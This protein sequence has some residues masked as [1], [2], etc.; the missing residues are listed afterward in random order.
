[1]KQPANEPSLLKGAF[2]GFAIATLIG[3]AITV[4]MSISAGEAT[5]GG[6]FSILAPIS[7]LGVYIGFAQ[8]VR[9]FEALNISVP[10]DNFVDFLLS[11]A[12]YTLVAV[13][14]LGSSAIAV[15]ITIVF[16]LVVARHG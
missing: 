14:L 12:G 3:V 13:V 7:A 2:I 11:S 10:F 5:P 16:D 8:T 9:R 1:M 15:L 6:G 4:G